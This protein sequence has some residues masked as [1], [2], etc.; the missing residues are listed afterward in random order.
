MHFLF[1]PVS[2]LSLLNGFISLLYSTFTELLSGE[3]FCLW[4]YCLFV[5]PCFLS[6]SSEFTF[7]SFLLNLPLF[8]SIGNC[9]FV[10]Q[11]FGNKK[12]AILFK[13]QNISKKSI[14]H[15]QFHVK[16]HHQ[17]KEKVL[18]CTEL[19]QWLDI[20]GNAVKCICKF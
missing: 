5:A 16:F 11:M 8:L 12:N 17:T 13:F 20:G 10:S 4:F 9:D 1:V 3:Q 7:S 18:L 14:S 19:V 2:L 6:F 15:I